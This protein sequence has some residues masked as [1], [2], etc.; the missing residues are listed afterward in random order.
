MS[1]PTV[2]LY[3][4]LPEI[5]RLRDSQQTPPGQLQAYLALVE[6]V[7]GDIHDNIEELYRDFFIETCSPWV[8]PYLGDLLGVSPLAGETWTLRADVADTIELRRMK[9]TIHAIE[10]L[11]YD[12]TGWAAHCVELREILTWHQHLNH[13]RP[14]LQTTLP[15]LAGVAR[16][17]TVAIKDPALLSLLGTPF[18][19]FA[20]YPD[21]KT[22]SLGTLRPNL[23]SLA[24]FLW[25]LQAYQAPVSMPVAVGQAALAPT[26][27]AGAKFAARFDME[28]SG[29]PIVLFNT[30]RS[31]PNAVPPVLST[32]DEVPGPIPM[33]RLTQAS[34][35]GVPLEYVSVNTW[36]ATAMDL[37]S[38]D[39]T[40]V[41][42]QFHLP[43]AEFPSDV[44][45][46]RGANLCAWESGLAPELNN[47]E[48]A[49]DPRNGRVV[50]GVETAAEAT[51]LEESM[52]VTYTYGAPGG[53]GVLAVGAQ[54]V[55]LDLPAE[56]TAATVNRRN[57]QRL[58]GAL[59]LQH[60]LDDLE[61][62]TGP[63]LV[64]IEDS[65]TYDLDLSAVSGATTENGIVT[66]N[67]KYPLA[68]A[69]VN[70]NRPLI[71]LKVPLAFRPAV[72]TAS[73]GEDQATIDALI[74]NL[75]VRL[76]G[77]YL[78]PETI[79]AAPLIARAAVATLEI[80]GCTL[81]PGS[82]QGLN[83]TAGPVI[84]A[85]TLDADFGFMA[86]SDDYDNFNVTPQIVIGQSI[87]GPL[88]M[89]AAYQLTVQGSIVDAGTPPG[90]S[91]STAIA[92]GSAQDPI[93][94]YG[95]PLS[96]QQSTFLGRLRVRSASGSGGIFC[97]ALEAWNNQV[98]CVRQSSFAGET[99]RL[100]QNFACVTGVAL[101]FTA[102]RFNQPGYAQLT[103]DTDER[104]LA[105]GP[106]DDQMGAFGPLL[107]AHKWIN[108]QIRLREYMPAGS[109][110]E[111]IPVT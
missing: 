111:I 18:D 100:P 34:P 69:A 43:Q 61:N 58:Q 101:D 14:D 66:L 1:T 11:A 44:W 84:A 20:H 55:D 110:P 48:I 96:F 98:G 3:S 16:G 56:W 78:T 92:I 103:F 17:G 40:N 71:R 31:D 109:R 41:G 104:V 22:I 60:A 64:A 80:S 94:G 21:L 24:I 70:G 51:A 2:P 79:G 85:M 28:P 89:E 37:N 83:G 76:Q 95:P 67:L 99:N 57:V 12:L 33:P 75:D 82:T 47:R 86:G 4:R 77:L 8:I 13:Q 26:A 39:V 91:G 63:V 6:E 88:L 59:G 68:I 29:K 30:S 106:N 45:T 107:E 74:T 97:H 36:D 81:D 15:Y 35:W 7:F 87:T 108:L 25:R 27:A 32:I 93:N 54:P 62:A 49:I 102:D 72:V 52:L 19:P 50:F 38:V 42:L 9:G 23:P 65:L 90:V 46:I 5:Y 10:L 105:S 73:G 53:P